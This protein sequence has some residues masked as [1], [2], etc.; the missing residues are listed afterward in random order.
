ML[1]GCDTMVSL[2][3]A[4]AGGQTVFAKNSDRPAD[5]CQPLVMRPRAEHPPGAE[6]RCQFVSLPEAPITYR[7]VGS[8]PYWCWG[9]EHGFNEHQ[10]VIGNEALPSKLAPAAQPRL[11]GMEVVR[12]ALERAATAREAVTV[13]TQ[14]I[15]RH[16]Q[17]EFENDRG[18]RTYDN[19]FLAADPREAFVLEA[20]GHDW[21]MRHAEDTHS[22]SNVGTLGAD[23]EQVSG[24][25][26]ATAAGLGLYDPVAGQP[27]QFAEA[28]ADRDRSASGLA[29]QRRS[30]ALLR[31][32]EGTIDARTMMRILSDHSDGAQPDEPF[33]EDPR[34]PESI[35]VHREEGHSRSATAASLVADLCS[36]DSRLP[37]YW[38]GLSSPCMTLL[39]PVFIQGDLPQALGIGGEMPSGDSPWWVFRRRALDGFRGG[40]E[41][42][43]EIRTAWTG[44]QNELFE[45]AYVMASQGKEM[46]EAG[47][48]REARRMLTEYMEQTVARMLRQADALGRVCA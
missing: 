44:L 38:C 27:F 4:S 21:A 42:R 9:Y 46:L 16:G 28:F 24:T 43:S 45:S 41:R 34:G 18:V 25:A 48:E 10:V 47:Q 8:R 22:I 23:A 37:V 2:G 33:V 1:N 29:R 39:Y 36:D 7:H 40:Q 11:V 30:A 35:C 15:E 17:G 19:L 13:M 12:L 5:E 26:S 3:A 14:V 6:T 32:H 31:K 20:A